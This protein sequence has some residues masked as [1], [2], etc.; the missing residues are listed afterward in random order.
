MSAF[1]IDEGYNYP[2]EGSTISVPQE[3]L[4]TY[5]D[6][7]TGRKLSLILRSKSLSVP[8]LKVGDNIEIFQHGKIIN[9]VPSP[10]Q[11]K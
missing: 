2:I 5:P 7:Q 8:P 9:G 11:S 6:L 10:N 3:I 4:D 1:Q